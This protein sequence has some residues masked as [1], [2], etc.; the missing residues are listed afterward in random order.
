MWEIHFIIG[1]KT[2]QLAAK[3]NNWQQNKIK[4]KIKTIKNNY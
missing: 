1:N 3:Q 2:K 4:L